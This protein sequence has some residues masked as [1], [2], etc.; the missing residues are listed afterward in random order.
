LHAPLSKIRDRLAR[1]AVGEWKADRDPA[2][3]RRAWF[4]GISASLCVAGIIGFF[5]ESAFSRHQ[6]VHDM[7]PFWTWRACVTLGV[8]LLLGMAVL[9]RRTPHTHVVLLDILLG[10]L[11]GAWFASY[12]ALTWYNERYDVTPAMRYAVRVESAYTTRHKNSTSYH[13]VVAKWP[14][15]RGETDLIVPEQEKLRLGAGD[16]VITIWHPGR[17]GDSWVSSFERS[18]AQD[19]YWENVE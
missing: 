12:A 11:P 19:C 10:A 9:V 14:D 8:V 2:L 18:V 3:R 15:G 5:V 17:L 1:I 4:A 7:I 6:I 16:C 13:L